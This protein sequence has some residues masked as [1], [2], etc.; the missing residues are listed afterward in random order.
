MAFLGTKK[1]ATF[2][3]RPVHHS[4]SLI[5]HIRGRFW[6]CSMISMLG[7][8]VTPNH[9]ARHLAKP[10]TPRAV[11]GIPLAAESCPVA[12]IFP[13]ITRAILSLVVDH[14]APRHTFLSLNMARASRRSDGLCRLAR[15]TSRL[16]AARSPSGSPAVAPELGVGPL[17]DA[18]GLQTNFLWL[19]Q[20]VVERDRGV[21]QE[22]ALRDHLDQPL[23]G[24]IIH[25]GQRLAEPIEVDAVF[26]SRP[27]QL[28]LDLQLRF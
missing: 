24:A 12:W 14:Y 3:G 11:V 1:A 17:D 5:S 13:P 10:T 18:Q 7:D 27:E 6:N 2:R 19:R 20:A 26:W 8:L 16:A 4:L 28:A 22:S 25:R 15:G 21:L 9:S 23:G